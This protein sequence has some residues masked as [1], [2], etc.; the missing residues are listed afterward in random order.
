[1]NFRVS[2]LTKGMVDFETEVQVSKGVAQISLSSKRGKAGEVHLIA[3]SKDLVSGL[4]V[5]PLKAKLLPEQLQ[6]K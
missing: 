5:V 4:L 3:E 6:I 1:M 2:D